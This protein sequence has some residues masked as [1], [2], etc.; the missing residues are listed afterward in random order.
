VCLAKHTLS[1][2]QF[3]S[4]GPEAQ[5]RPDINIPC[6]FYRAGSSPVIWPG[7]YPAGPVWS[8]AK[9]VTQLATVACMRM[10]Q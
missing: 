2:K 5:A 9:P 7:M 10:Q 4:A 6:F 1:S 8:L 3:G